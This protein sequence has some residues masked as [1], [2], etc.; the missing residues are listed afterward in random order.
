MTTLSDQE[1]AQSFEYCKTHH[2]AGA[3]DALGWAFLARGYVLNAG[4][5]FRQCDE[6]TIQAGKGM[7]GRTLDGI[8]WNQYPI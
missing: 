1:L 4:Y 8:E 3:W 6:V 2:D 7:T 5:C